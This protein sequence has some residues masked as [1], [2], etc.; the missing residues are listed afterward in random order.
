M[1]QIAYV[2]IHRQDNSSLQNHPSPLR[3]PRDRHPSFLIAELSVPAL[4]LA[5]LCVDVTVGL[6]FGVAIRSWR[7]SESRNPRSSRLSWPVVAY[8]YEPFANDADAAVAL[9][10]LDVSCRSARIR[11]ELRGD[12][13]WSRSMASVSPRNPVS[14][15]WSRPK[16]GSTRRDGGCGRTGRTDAAP[17]VVVGGCWRTTATAGTPRWYQYRCNAPAWRE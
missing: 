16:V 1:L 9:P 7:H 12:A 13:R 8:D 6:L 17:S 4:L 10:R 5:S 2:G 14:C 15:F 11:R 3:R